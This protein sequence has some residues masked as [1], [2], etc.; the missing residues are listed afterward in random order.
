MTVT[1]SQNS[2]RHT[3][4]E[5]IFYPLV[6]INKSLSYI[7]YIYEPSN[8]IFQYI[9]T[10]ITKLVCRFNYIH[11]DKKNHTLR[12]RKS[13]GYLLCIASELNSTILEPPSWIHEFWWK[14]HDLR[15]RKPYFE[16]NLTIINKFHLVR[17][18]GAA[19]LFLSLT[20]SLMHSQRN[21]EPLPNLKLIRHREGSQIQLV[22]FD[23]TGSG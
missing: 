12:L 4:K 20:N 7:F 21:Y 5:I 18:C 3:F 1:S 10:L 9:R 14:N 8:T 17:Y 22:G 19:I 23:Y 16:L 2:L 6:H 11:F 15:P 13:S